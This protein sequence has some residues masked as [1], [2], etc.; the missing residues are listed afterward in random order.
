[1]IRITRTSF[2][3]GAVALALAQNLLLAAV[4]AQAADLFADTV[5]AKGKGFVIKQSEWDAA[6]INYKAGVAGQGGS[7]PEDQRDPIRSNLLQHL[8]VTQLLL[9]KSTPADKTN[10]EAKVDKALA[11]AKKDAPS[12]EI[13]DAQIKATGMTLDQVRARA[14]EQ[15]TCERVLEREIK[16][17]IVIPDSAI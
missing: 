7:V 10:S 12:P 5:V 8:I 4:P 3:C 2:C 13:F 1:M 14:C 15:Q 16:S 6:F 11:D 9:A 17:K